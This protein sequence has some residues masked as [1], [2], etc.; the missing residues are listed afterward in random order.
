[1]NIKPFGRTAMNEVNTSSMSREELESTASDLGVT[2]PHNI[3]DDKLGAKIDAA[4]GGTVKN[5]GDGDT[6][7]KDPKVITADGAAPAD[8]ERKFEILIATHDQDKQPVQLGLNGRSIVIQRGKKVIVTQ[9][10]KEILEHAEQF[11]YDAEMNRQSIQS[12]PFQVTR[13]VTDKG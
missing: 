9:S 5:D 10:V 7:T 13:E 11:V 8:K 6:A 12:Y 3:S 4:L 2:Y 1:M